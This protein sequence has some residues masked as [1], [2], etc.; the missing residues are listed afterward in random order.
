MT[1]VHAVTA[2]LEPENIAGPMV[3]LD[4]DAVSYITGESYKIN[5]SN[6]RFRLS[7]RI[8]STFKHFPSLSEGTLRGRFTCD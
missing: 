2:F 6:Y 8:I 1:K 3:F 4:R 5:R 7:G